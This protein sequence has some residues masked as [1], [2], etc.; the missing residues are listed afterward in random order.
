MTVYTGIAPMQAETTEGE[1]KLLKASM[2]GNSEAFGMIVERYQS[3][4]CAITYSATGDFHRSRELAQ[5]TFLRAWRSI[6]QLRDLKSFRSWLC[7]IARNVANRSIR[8]ERFDVINAPEALDSA[9]TA[10][11]KEPD[12]GE[13]AISSEQQAAVWAALEGIP[14]AYREPLILFYRQQQSVA[15]VADDLGLSEN[16]A[17]QRLSRGRNLLRAEVASLVEDVLGRTA[18]KKA[19]ALALVAALPALAPQTAAAGVAAVAAKGS[20]AAKSAFATGLLG[21]VFGPLLGILGGLFGSWMS[22]KNT[23][24][25]RERRFMVRM[26]LLMWGEI[27]V[28]LV[29][30][31]GLGVLALKGFV[32]KSAFWAIFAVLMTA[33]FVMLAPV[34]IWSNRRQRQIQREEGTFVKPDYRPVEPS[35]GNIYAVFGGSI[36]GAVAWVL[37]VWLITGDWLSALIVA[38][39]AIAIFAV[40]VRACIADRTR[41]RQVVML[42]VIGLLILDLAVINLGWNR[43]TPHFAESTFA[44]RTAS[45]P[46]WMVN[47]ALVAVFGGLLMIFAQ[48]RRRDKHPAKESSGE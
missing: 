26:T 17:K 41:Y 39:V 24:S 44:A 28:L 36:F 31:G 25:Q 27:V 11:A 48:I 38:I 5:E 19:F 8:K 30:L 37:P 12:P 34:I 6:R 20:P 2:A 13:V 40:S 15:Q 3:L 45:I 7:R 14:E 43:W 18:P 47:V 29:I 22:I 21:A 42:D 35:K 16:A 46:L 1:A 9:E 23:Q 33:H 10:A 32:P 4:I